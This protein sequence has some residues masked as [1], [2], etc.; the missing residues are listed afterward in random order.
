[1]SEKGLYCNGTQFQI[2]GSDRVIRF[3]FVNSGCSIGVL[4]IVSETV[5]D[6]TKT[7]QSRFVIN[8]NQ[9]NTVK[10]INRNKH[11]TLWVNDKELFSGNY[12]TSLG[13]IQGV[14]LEFD[15]NGYV[16]S[17]DL[18]SLDGKSLYHF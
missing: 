5:Y 1:M 15:R 9:W 13:E 6:G 14:W 3:K 2:T 17:C 16:K 18:N 11:V 4:N 8:L 7:N 10:L 12:E